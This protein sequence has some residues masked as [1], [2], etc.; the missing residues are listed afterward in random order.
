V[1]SRFQA[2]AFKF[3]VYRYTPAEATAAERAV[4]WRERVELSEE[5]GEEEE[6][7][8]LP[9]TPPAL[10]GGGGGGGDGG[11]GGGGGGG[12][13]GGGGGG[14]GGG[15]PSG[16]LRAAQVGLSLPGVILVT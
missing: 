6:E 5:E 11:F 3:N 7:D 13:G 9:S 1:K 8:P 12:M 14:G 16:C 10:G 2:F 15:T 4:A